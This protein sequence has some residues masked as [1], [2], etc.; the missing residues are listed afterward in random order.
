MWTKHPDLKRYVTISWQHPIH[1][2]GMFAFQQKL[3]RI[4]AALKMWNTEVFGNIFQNIMNVEQRVKVAEQAYNGNP[5]DENLIAMNKATTKLTF[6]LLVEESY[7][8]QKVVCK[9]LE[10]GEK[11]T[12]YFH[13]LTKKK[14]KQSR[15]YKIQH[16]GATLTKTEDIKNSDVNYFKQ[17]F[18]MDDMVSVDDLH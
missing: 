5:S 16:N 17:A 18:T 9:W 15:I 2:R 10:E 3:H 8:K 14:R 4:K 13:S 1:S 12:K 11:N 7:W 6:A